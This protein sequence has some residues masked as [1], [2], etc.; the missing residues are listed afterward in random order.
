MGRAG[1]PLDERDPLKVFYCGGVQWFVRS[2]GTVHSGSL[3]GIIV[4]FYATFDR[5]WHSSTCLGWSLSSPR[6][7]IAQVQRGPILTRGPQNFMTLV[8]LLRALSQLVIAF[9][10]QFSVAIGE[11]HWIVCLSLCLLQHMYL[12]QSWLVSVRRS[13]TQTTGLWADLQHSFISL[14]SKCVVLVACRQLEVLFCYCACIPE[15]QYLEKNFTLPEYSSEVCIVLKHHNL[16]NECG[17]RD[18]SCHHNIEI[19][20]AALGR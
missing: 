9:K 1:R 16:H 3:C 12:L 10:I 19:A 8:W 18:Q 11:P 15:P 5:S 13:Q 6:L 14:Q 17:R 4:P 2:T 7:A 20:Q